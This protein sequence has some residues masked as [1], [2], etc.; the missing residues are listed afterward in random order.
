M[1]TDGE[2]ISPRHRKLTQAV[3]GKELTPQQ[4]VTRICGDVQSRGLP[5]V[6]HYTEQFDKVKLTPGTVRV[7]TEELKEA[8]VRKPTRSCSTWFAASA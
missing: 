7:T 4:V 2:V 1:S 3:F 5:S 6:L 8:H